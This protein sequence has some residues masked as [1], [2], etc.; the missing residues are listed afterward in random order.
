[1]E[2]IRS[3][4]KTRDEIKNVGQTEHLFQVETGSSKLHVFCIPKKEL[5]TYEVEISFAP[6]M[7]FSHVNNSLFL[8]GGRTGIYPNYKYL[9]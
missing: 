9:P 8:C 6:G 4:I 7:G 3:K 5:K 2:L 1:M